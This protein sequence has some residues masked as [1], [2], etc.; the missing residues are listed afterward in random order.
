MFDLF[1]LQ[2]LKSYAY[3][4]TN[5]ELGEKI[6]KQIAILEEIEELED[7]I[8]NK[9]KQG[10]NYW[11]IAKEFPNTCYSIVKDDIYLVYLQNFLI[12]FEAS[13]FKIMKDN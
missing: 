8:N 9:Y 6:E 10:Y 4:E 5:V 2:K 12:I 7:Y 13:T 1:D 3:A 11:D